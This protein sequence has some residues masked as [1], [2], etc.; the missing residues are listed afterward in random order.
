MKNKYLNL[1][2]K[3]NFGTKMKIIEYK[4]YSDITIEFQDK[5]KAKV[6]T[7]CGN[8]KKGN[9][10][11]PYDKMVCGVG[12]LG[13]GKYN[14]K[15]YPLIYNYWSRLIRRCYDPY[16]LNRQP[17]YIDCYVE[18]DLLCFQNFAKWYEEN[19][20]EI[21]GEKMCLDKDI[22]VKGNKIYSKETMIF[23]PSRINELFTKRQNERGV[24]PLGTSPHKYAEK[25][26]VMCSNGYGK[27]IY[28]GLFE[29]KRN[30]WLMYK[31]N[32]ELVIQSIADEYKDLIPQKLYEALYSYKVEIND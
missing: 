3:N 19:Y 5:H 21:K 23:V 27:N 7:S 12:Y 16:Y 10:K 8:F 24:S 30:A 9:V 22:L 28:L 11:N 31:I 13:E 4:K 17:T 29:N 1:I 18:E 25:M 6:K 15:D 26:Q 32:K 2:N 20:Y 14:Y